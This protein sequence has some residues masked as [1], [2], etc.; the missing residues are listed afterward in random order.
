[1]VRQLYDNNVEAGERKTLIASRAATLRQAQG[2]N[3]LGAECKMLS[4]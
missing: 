3:A 4:N 1:M 2:D